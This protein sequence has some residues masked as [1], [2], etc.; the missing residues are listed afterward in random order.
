[1]K[2]E[3]VVCGHLSFSHMPLAIPPGGSLAIEPDMRTSVDG[4]V[5]LHG[6]TVVQLTPVKEAGQ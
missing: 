2:V 4:M 6:V 1:M 3:R 5:W